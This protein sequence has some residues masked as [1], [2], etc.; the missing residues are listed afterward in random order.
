MLRSK[1]LKLSPSV[2]I[3]AEWKDRYASALA[4]WALPT[5]VSVSVSTVDAT[6]WRQ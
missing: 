2:N 3:W 6:T 5:E 1:P 4:S